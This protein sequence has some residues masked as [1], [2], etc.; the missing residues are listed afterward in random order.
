[1]LAR[2][3]GLS[4]VV[5]VVV[6][7]V[8]GN[9]PPTEGGVEH[10]SE[11]GVEHHPRL[12]TPAVP[13]AVRDRAS[14][15]SRVSG[16]GQDGSDPPFCAAVAARREGGVEHRVE[17]PAEHPPPAVGGGRSR[18]IYPCGKANRPAVGGRS[19]R[20]GAAP[21]VTCCSA[22]SSSCSA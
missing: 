9:V 20:R 18:R 19:R 8:V 2:R 3:V 14:I 22:R 1:M 12:F 11:G 15:P 7:V 13:R 16:E 5:A 10:R 6:A 17:H 4:V 21:C